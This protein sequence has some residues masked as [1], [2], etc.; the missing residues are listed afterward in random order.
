MAADSYI[1]NSSFEDNANEYIFESK[2]YVYGIDSNGGAYPSGSVSFNL[3]NLAANMN[4]IDWKNSVL[5]IPIVA[6]VEITGPT[7]ATNVDANAYTFSVKNFGHLIHSMTIKIGNQQC[8]D[9]CAF[10]NLD[11]NYKVLSSFSENDLKTLGPSIG[12]YKD[13]V[14]GIGYASAASADG[15]GEFN[16][17]PYN[18]LPNKDN[19]FLAQVGYKHNSAIFEKQKDTA[20]D[21]T[22]DA[23][24]FISRQNVVMSSKNF[25]ERDVVAGTA[26]PGTNAIVTHYILATIPLKYLHDIFDKMPLV[27]SCLVDLVINTNINATCNIVGNATQFTTVNVT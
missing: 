18:V 14:E 24:L 8:A 23:N 25:C 27:R 20:F 19:G 22:G 21:L 9:L 10:S 7:N 3:N 11:I 15:L 17:D 1:Y 16:N 13:G 26:L 5:T 6:R 4:L 12:F 2:K